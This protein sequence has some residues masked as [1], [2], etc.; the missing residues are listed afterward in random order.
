MQIARGK[1]TVFLRLFPQSSDCAAVPRLPSLFHSAY[2]I[3]RFLARCKAQ[4]RQKERGIS[5]S[6]SRP[7][8][9][10]RSAWCLDIPPC[11]ARPARDGA[12]SAEKGGF[13]RNPPL[14]DGITILTVPHNIISFS[15]QKSA[16]HRHPLMIAG[17]SLGHIVC[18]AYRAKCR[19]DRGKIG[20]KAANYRTKMLRR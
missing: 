19:A 3:P 17:L 11:A 9:S 13:Q 12:L 16:P 8:P 1:F 15:A 2:H 6:P 20:K 10:C 4:F 18:P 14:F 7:M 5:S